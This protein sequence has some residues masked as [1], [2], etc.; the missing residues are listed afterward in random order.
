MGS[1]MSKGG[2]LEARLD[3][4]RKARTLEIGAVTIL[5][6]TV[7]EGNP[8]ASRFLA[9]EELAGGKKNLGKMPKRCGWGSSFPQSVQGRERPMAEAPQHK[10][11]MPPVARK[12]ASE[13]KFSMEPR[14]PAL[15]VHG[16]KSRY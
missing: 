13:F 2:R 14:A 16:I 15:V 11:V 4:P 1:L 9:A 3:N 7:T 10:T 12:G 5:C 8:C 6:F